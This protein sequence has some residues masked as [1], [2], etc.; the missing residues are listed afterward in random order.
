MQN[1]TPEEWVPPI[2]LVSLWD[3]GTFCLSN[4][5]PL[6]NKLLLQNIRVS[7]SQNPAFSP[8]SQLASWFLSPN[9]GYTWASSTIYALGLQYNCLAFLNLHCLT[10]RTPGIVLPRFFHFSYLKSILIYRCHERNILDN[11]LSETSTWAKRD[12]SV[13]NVVK[14]EDLSVMFNT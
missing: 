2:S 9:C 4:Y 6:L 5:T 1:C 8:Q 12:G 7:S 3:L 14:H 11:F 10:P 13:G